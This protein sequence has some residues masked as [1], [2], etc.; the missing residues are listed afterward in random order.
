MSRDPIGEKGTIAFI[1][2]S[3]V[4]PGSGLE[5]MQ[6]LLGADDK[7]GLLYAFC[8]NAGVDG[9][10][11]FG[12]RECCGQ[13]DVT[14]LVGVALREVGEWFESRPEDKQESVCTA[15][16]GIDTAATA[17]VRAGS[18]LRIENS[19]EWVKPLE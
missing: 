15:L 18:A 14:Y 6:A 10:D 16:Y 11:L 3:A 12:L 8:G 17:W 4:L 1:R 5:M 19:V 9:V 2:N 7:A 13:A